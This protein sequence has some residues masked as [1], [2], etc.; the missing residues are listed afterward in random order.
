MYII[1]LKQTMQRVLLFILILFL[2]T[3]CE[4]EEVAANTLIGK[5]QWLRTDGGW[6]VDDTPASTGTT[7]ELEFKKGNKF[8]EYTN[9]ALTAQGI[10]RFKTKRC[11]HDHSEKQVIHFS[12]GK[13]MMIEHLDAESLLLSN[14]FYDG[15][16][17]QYRRILEDE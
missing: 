6:G 14:D 2:S 17:S 8:K 7:I 9:G 13:K 15:T 16:N 5:W 1:Y 4:K 12:S 10:I 11:I 3:S